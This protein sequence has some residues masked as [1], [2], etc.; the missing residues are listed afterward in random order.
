MEGGLRQ[1]ELVAADHVPTRRQERAQHQVLCSVRLHSAK[2]VGHCKGIRF[3]IG[4]EQ[5][6]ERQCGSGGTFAV[7][8]GGLW[9]CVFSLVR[10]PVHQ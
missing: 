3:D 2:F 1:K 10:G 5:A 9:I 6:R 4:L 8:V 7:A